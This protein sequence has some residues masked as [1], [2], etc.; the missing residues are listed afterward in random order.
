MGKNP[1]SSTHIVTLV[2]PRPVMNVN[3]ASGSVTTAITSVAQFKWRGRLLDIHLD[4]TRGS[5]SI[6]IAPQNGSPQCTAGI[7]EA[8]VHNLQC[9]A[10][11][12]LEYDATRAK[13]VEDGEAVRVD[14]KRP[15]PRHSLRPRKAD[16]VL[17][18]RPQIEELI[19]PL[20]LEP[21]QK[22]ALRPFQESGVQWLTDHKAGILA[23]DMG[24]GKTAQALR[25]LEGLVERG[26]IRSA[27]V[28][29][30]KSLIANWEAECARWVPG[31]T[32]MRCVP[33]QAEADEVWSAIIGRSHIIITSY[34][35]L[36]P[37]A[38]PLISHRVELVVADEAHRLR[39]S[40]SKLVQGFRQIN[41][42]RIWA[43][44]GTPI[45]RHEV[46]LATLLSLLE[47][48][49]FSVK[50]VAVESG[51]LRARARPYLLR[52]LKMDVLAELPEMIDT[53]E[54]LELTPQ[55][56]RAYHA[57]RSQ[58]LSNDV[59]EAL[60][61]FTLLRSLCDIDPSSESSAK[62]DRIVDILKL[63]KEGEE[64]AVVFSY[65]LHPLDVLRKRLARDH[66]SLETVSLTGELT[67]DERERVIQKFKSDERIVALLCSSRVGG[68]GLT[69]TEANHVVFI[70]EWWNPSANAQARDRVVR[71]GQKRVVQVHRFRCQGTIEEALDQIL[72]RKSEAF[73]N[74][75]DA[76]ATGAQ[77]SVAESNEFL[78]EIL[79]E[80]SLLQAGVRL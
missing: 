59:G 63:V 11:I 61:R 12:V 33:A 22:P 30:P 69:L 51:G 9:A 34:E 68:E 19:A 7:D 80:I 49:K 65:L 54:R 21:T 4:A 79:G 52:R 44:T 47:P 24:L 25:A 35:Q 2:T 56:Y 58:S 26:I 46:D 10:N 37:L 64:K 14:V 3:S 40:Q 1:S 77:L 57:A 75:V 72:D 50:S 18:L 29:C 38:K 76:L 16:E 41:V 28:I 20:V 42:E 53:K 32:V 36:R 71:L 70:N 66:P 5:C 31:L 62:L 78:D 45:E 55:Q 39:R 8:Q 67:A 23:D 27:L 6:V 48:T 74:V 60:H 15:R 13:A 73:A 43:L 17:S